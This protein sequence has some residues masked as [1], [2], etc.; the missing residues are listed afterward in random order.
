MSSRAKRHE[1]LRKKIRTAILRKRRGLRVNFAPEPPSV[2]KTTTEPQRRLLHPA[3]DLNSTLE[4]S[5][6]RCSPPA[7][8]ASS[9][10]T[11]PFGNF[12]PTKTSSLPALNAPRSA[13]PIPRRDSV[14]RCTSTSSA[15]IPTTTTFQSPP[16]PQ[17]RSPKTKSPVRSPIRTRSQTQ[18]SRTL[19]PSSPVTI[20]RCISKGRLRTNLS[21]R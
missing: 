13:T 5:N 9:S 10:D 4:R 15:S 11:E 3:E 8:V 17:Q 21:K 19:Q 1:E 6:S 20:R 7:S 2:Q 18:Q 14:E 16:S 12:M